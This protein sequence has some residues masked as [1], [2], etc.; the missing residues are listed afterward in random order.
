[1]P[2]GLG[3]AASHAPGAYAK[4]QEEMDMLW[5][6]LSLS[7]GIPQPAYAA[8]ETG[9][10]FKDMLNRINASHQ[11]LIDAFDEYKPDLLIIIGGDQTE[12]FDR[13]NVPQFMIYTG[14]DSWAMK[15][16]ASRNPDGPR[17][18]A[19]T[20]VDFAN[21][22]LKKLVKEE[23]FDVAFSDTMENFGRGHGLPHAF[24]NML[25]YIM[26]NTRVPA[27]MV[28]ENTYD[29]PSLT[30]KR[31]YEFGQAIARICKQSDKRIAIMGSGGLAH[32][33][34]GKRSGWLDQPL[35][36]WCLEQFAEGNGK[37]T[38]AMFS[39]DSDTMVAGTGE[40]RAWIT[41]A[42]AMEEMGA[43]AKVLDYVPAAKTVTG[44]GF[45]YWVA[46]SAVPAGAR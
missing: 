27:I 13:S 37:A 46:P 19:E 21:W 28:Y 9:E 5:D 41:V 30:A 45:A 40:I 2:I 25:S 33:P 10:K 20:D 4:S 44:L 7:R 35:D 6:R 15:A 23:G 24:G 38:Q 8:E 29:P 17:V 36:K 18:T 31:C 16:A 26:D 34:G 42:G 39:Y 12:M 1:M 3:L 14:R 43:R 22:L 11:G 32:D